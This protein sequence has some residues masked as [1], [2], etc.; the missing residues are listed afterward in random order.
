MACEH[1]RLRCT[2]CRWFCVEC[3]AEVANPYEQDKH[4]GQEE[5][6]VEAPKKAV[7][8][9]AKKEAQE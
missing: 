2:D 3:G 8:R 6:P 4:I 1:K 7:K 5:K 9:R